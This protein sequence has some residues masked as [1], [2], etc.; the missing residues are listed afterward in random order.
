M[1]LK[2]RSSRYGGIVSWTSKYMVM[3]VGADTNVPFCNDDP[4]DNRNPCNCRP[5]AWF[6]ANPLHPYPPIPFTRPY[7]DDATS[8]N[9]LVATVRKSNASRAE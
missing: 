8:G 6:E 2:Y 5:I 3:E 7:S 1:E 4:E 9:Y